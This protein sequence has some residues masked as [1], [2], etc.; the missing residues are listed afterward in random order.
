MATR[1]S[2]DVNADDMQKETWVFV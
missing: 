1:A 2:E